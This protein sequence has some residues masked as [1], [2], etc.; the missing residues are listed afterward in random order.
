MKKPFKQ[1]K[2]PVVQVRSKISNDIFYHSKSFPTK[3]ID[4]KLFIGV[5]KNEK[6]SDIFFMKKENMEFV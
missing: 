4:G 3:E 2:E 5:K 6:D 1:R